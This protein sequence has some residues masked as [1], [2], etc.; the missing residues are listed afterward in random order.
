MVNIQTHEVIMRYLK[1]R[2]GNPNGGNPSDTDPVSL[3]AQ[4][5]TE[6]YNVIIDHCSLMW[7]TDIGGLSILTNVHDV[8]IQDSIIGEGLRNRATLNPPLQRVNITQLNTSWQPTRI[9]LYRNLITTSNERNPQV[10]GAVNTDIVNNVIYNWG[11]KA[12]FGNP[13][14]LNLIKNYY[15]AGPES[16][17]VPAW[18]LRTNP[19]NPEAH[20][21]SVYEE[22]TLLEG[23]DLVR[24]GTPEIYAATR[25][26]PYS[27]KNEMT[28]KAAYDTI[29]ANAGASLPV[30]DSVDQRVIDNLV[31]RKGTFLD[32]KDL[33]WP[34][35]APG[36]P[37]ADL[38][39]NGLPDAWEKRYLCP[40]T[41]ACTTAASRDS[42][43]DGYTDIEE[44]L[45]GTNPLQ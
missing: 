9:T 41:I 35:L 16:H 7:G 1:V 15:I 43:G 29:V 45:N 31:K 44:Y 8:T 20:P 25:F 10:Q 27:V 4:E 13:R 33:V 18:S 14:S 32:A 38:N 36:V 42:D 2:L 30:R 6:I 21:A 28:P 26:A 22:G 11:E 37:A 24:G 17:I 5:G 40:R 12:S 19:E 39:G 34:E 3:S 23:I